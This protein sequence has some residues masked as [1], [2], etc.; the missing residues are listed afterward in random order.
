MSKNF[1]IAFGR[2]KK[3][4][5][6]IHRKQTDPNRKIIIGYFFLLP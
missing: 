5:H 4:V 3:K 2:L 6:S 1:L